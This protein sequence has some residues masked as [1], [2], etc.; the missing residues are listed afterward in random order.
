MQ[1]SRMRRV[2][3]L[4]NLSIIARDKLKVCLGAQTRENSHRRARYCNVEGPAVLEKS[5]AVRMFF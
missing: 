2:R 3:L 4:R 5:G 1:K